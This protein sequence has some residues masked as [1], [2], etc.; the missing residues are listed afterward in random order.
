MYIVYDWGIGESC[1]SYMYIYW[2]SKPEL[3]VLLLA[4]KILT[5]LDG[6]GQNGDVSKYDIYIYIHH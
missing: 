1:Y 5:H 3:Q 6:R 2:I 4:L